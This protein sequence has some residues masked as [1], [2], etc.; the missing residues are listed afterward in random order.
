MQDPITGGPLP[1]FPTTPATSGPGV[2]PHSAH[3]IRPK[4]QD[5][6]PLAVDQG[7]LTAPA[8]QINYLSRADMLRSAPYI[9]AAHGGEPVQSCRLR[10]GRYG[11][12]GEP[13]EGYAGGCRLGRGLVRGAESG[14]EHFAKA[15]LARG[16]Q[17]QVVRNRGDHQAAVQAG[18][19][20]P[21]HGPKPVCHGL[22]QERTAVADVMAAQSTYRCSVLH[23]A[24]RHAGF[25]AP[26]GSRHCMFEER[27]VAPCT[28]P[29]G[30]SHPGM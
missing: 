19:A 20:D 3:T 22:P 29:A 1:F 30:W 26:P 2:V 27:A 13:L 9:Q 16:T 15:V 14:P 12:S 18:T 6:K 11:G 21:L 8:P 17:V 10:S 5:A 24:N 28:R 23:C 4:R 25:R 7:N